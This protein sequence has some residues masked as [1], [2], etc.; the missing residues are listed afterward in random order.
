MAR[1]ESSSRTSSSDPS[2][3]LGTTRT[4]SGAGRG[5]PEKAPPTA[6]PRTL[7]PRPIAPSPAKSTL[8]FPCAPENPLARPVA[9]GDRKQ[10][11]AKAYPDASRF[12]V[13]LHVLVARQAR[14]VRDRFAHVGDRQRRADSRLD[15]AE[16]ERIGNDLP[17]L[18]D[19]NVA[20]RRRLCEG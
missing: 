4:R 20:D 9:S 19:A 18:L 7:E 2:P 17:F 10:H 15:Q 1:L 13:D 14:E 5:P 16:N 3:R 6:G 8:A 12:L 11:V